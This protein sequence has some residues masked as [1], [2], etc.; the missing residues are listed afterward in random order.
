MAK[1]KASAPAAE[2]KPKA[3]LKYKVPKQVGAAI[4][5]LMKVRT[6]R[7]KIQA[8]AEAE[9]AQEDMIEDAIFAMFDK[10]AL[11]GARGKAAQASI[12]RS[13]VPT[14][15]DWDKFAAHVIKTKSLDLLQR[16]PSVEAVRERWAAKVG[17]PGIEVFTKISLNLTK[18]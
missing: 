2:E 8:Q 5:L 13:D 17:V 11:E 18:V 3:K 10:G 6:E 16:R 12:K 1:R 15:V 4:D 9:K 14:V 7:K